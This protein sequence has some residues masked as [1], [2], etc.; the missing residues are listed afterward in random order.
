MHV[1]WK[2]R[3]TFYYLNDFQHCEDISTLQSQFGSEVF[4]FTQIVLLLYVI[5]ILSLLPA[6]M[7]EDSYSAYE[8]ALEWLAPTDGEKSHILVAMAAVAYKCQG[9]E[10]CKSLLFRW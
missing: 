9:V 2:R 7:Y 5:F 10:D 1:T 6:K 3:G 8:T 4:L